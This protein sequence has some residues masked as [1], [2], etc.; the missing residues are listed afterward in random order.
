MI[1]RYK[2]LC[3]ALSV[4]LIGVSCQGETVN[5]NGEKIMGRWSAYERT[6]ANGDTLM[7]TGIR[8]TLISDIEFMNGSIVKD[9]STEDFFYDFRLEGDTLILGRKEYIISFI[10]NDT[11]IMKEKKGLISD[12]GFINYLKRY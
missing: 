5:G 2:F 10:G 12:G 9:Y 11:L 7:S 1:I 4:L 3:L 6:T 8:T